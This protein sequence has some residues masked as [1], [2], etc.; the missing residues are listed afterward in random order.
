MTIK[1]FIKKAIAGGWMYTHKEYLEMLKPWGGKNKDRKIDTC[2][3]LIL[4]EG[5]EK[6]LL[7]PKAWQAVGK[8]ERWPE[9]TEIDHGNWDDMK[10]M[11]TESVL[12]S[13]H[14]IHQMI[15]FIC[16]GGT[17]KE[18]VKTL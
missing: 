7:D 12:T 6:T 10:T 14:K 17:I 3:T 8:V 13:K 2:I 9:K 5:L 11:T 4:K 15:D 18:Y 16:E 1:Q